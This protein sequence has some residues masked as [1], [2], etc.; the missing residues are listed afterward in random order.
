MSRSKLSLT[1]SPF[2]A[3]APTKLQATGILYGQTGMLKTSL[4][5]S[6]CPQPIVSLNF[7]GGRD[8]QALHRAQDQGVEVYRAPILMT[9]K[10]DSMEADQAKRVATKYADEFWKAYQWA[11][12]KGKKNEVGTIVID[13]FEELK[14]ILCGSICGRTEIAFKQNRAKGALNKLCRDL[15]F[16]AKQGKAHLMIVARETEIYVDDK[17]TGRYKPRVPPAL[18]EVVDWAGYVKVE[19]K[20]RG[21]E[22]DIIP[23]ITMSKCGGNWLEMGKT[24]TPDDWIDP[25]TGEND[26]PFAWIC[27]NQWTKSKIEDWK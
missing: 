22:V 5:F 26:G 17:G 8:I 9:E 14:P 16:M 12:E 2:S 11:I 27:Y 1:G 4:I 7:D 21:K 15:I 6:H 10:I 23:R 25:D 19:A 20:K 24:Y 3:S 13:T 18:L